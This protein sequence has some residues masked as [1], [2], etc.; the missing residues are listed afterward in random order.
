MATT[1]FK[2]FNNKFAHAAKRFQPATPPPALGDLNDFTRMDS[3]AEAIWSEMGGHERDRKI[4]EEAA[5]LFKDKLPEA[6]TP[7]LVTYLWLQKKGLQFEYQVEAAGGRS[8]TGGSVVDFLVHGSRVWAW[9]IQGHYFH[10]APDKAAKDEIAKKFL[11]GATTSSGYQ[12]DGVVDVWDFQ[13]Y[14]DRENVLTLATVGIQL[15]VEL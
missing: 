8:T 12:I 14:Q 7:E 10:S 3:K 1:A 2:T 13:I 11:I 4:A 6:T 15:D 5:A 9:R